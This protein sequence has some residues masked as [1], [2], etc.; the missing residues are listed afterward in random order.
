MNFHWPTDDT[1]RIGTLQE[2]RSPRV[3]EAVQTEEIDD[4]L[5]QSVALVARSVAGLAKNQRRVRYFGFETT[6][7]QDSR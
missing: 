3:D 6:H 4:W 7:E 1:Q 2:L 5:E